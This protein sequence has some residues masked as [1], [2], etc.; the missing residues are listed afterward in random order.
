MTGEPTFVD[1]NVLVYAYDADAGAKHQP[2]QSQLQ[3][4]WETSPDC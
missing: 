1:T 2:A 4:L 3:A